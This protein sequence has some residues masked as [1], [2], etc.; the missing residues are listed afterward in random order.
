MAA[1]KSQGSRFTLFMAGLT[2]VCAG[3]AFFDSGIAK[4][5]LILG[6]V[7]VLA[8]L[9]GFF[10]IKPL[11]GKTGNTPQPAVTKLIGVIVVVAGWLFVLFGLHLTTAVGAR[12]FTSTL[13]F[14]V[15]LF[16]I[17]FILAPAVNKN[18][19]WKG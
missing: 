19:I 9:W 6:L 11:E 10:K 14:A 17:C 1:T 5:A 13:G 15:S 16:G 7:A 2:A 12:L 8:A 18:A 3:I 4:F